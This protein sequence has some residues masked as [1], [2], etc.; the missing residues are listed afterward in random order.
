M[1]P[2]EQKEETPDIQITLD[3]ITKQIEKRKL[4]QLQTYEIHN[5]QK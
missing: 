5:I 4:K 3:K 1:K 2:E